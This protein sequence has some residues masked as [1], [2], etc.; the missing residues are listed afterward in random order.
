M[1]HHIQGDHWYCYT[2]YRKI[3]NNVSPSTGISVIPFI[4]YKEIIMLHYL[5]SLCLS[6]C[7]FVYLSPTLYLFIYIYIYICTYIYLYVYHTLRQH[8]I[9]AIE[10]V[11]A[12]RETGV[13]CTK[14]WLLPT[15][16]N[17]TK[18]LLH[19]NVYIYIYILLHYNIQYKGKTQ[20]QTRNKFIYQSLL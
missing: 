8:T 18:L 3:T 14:D 20:F 11:W 16:D 2:K 15:F 5:P 1:F 7:I 10:R 4:T 17:I 13:M 9:C 6:I 12:C 19:Y